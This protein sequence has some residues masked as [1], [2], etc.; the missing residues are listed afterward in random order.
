MS[1]TPEIGSL[2]GTWTYRSLVNDAKLD[3]P[4]DQLEF[5]RGTIEIAHSPMGIFTGRIFGP[6]WALQLKGATSYGNPFAVRF[7][8]TGIVGGEPWAYDYLGYLSPPWPAGIDQ[9]PAI[10]GSVTR[11][12]PHSNGQGGVAPAGVVCTWFAVL[13][14]ASPGAP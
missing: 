9:R 11:T 6:G 12:I 14:A 4:F 1:F 5:G 8:G 10:A 13:D 3:T 7:Q 2:A